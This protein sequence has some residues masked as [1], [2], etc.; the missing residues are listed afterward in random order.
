MGRDSALGLPTWER[1]EEL[2]ATATLAVVDRAGVGAALPD[3]PGAQVEIVP[4]RRI[5]VSSTELRRMVADGRPIVPLVP[6]AVADL[7]A[8]H[9]LYR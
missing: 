3:L 1:H 5:E 8:E 4:M 9:G 7:V 6:P 2:L